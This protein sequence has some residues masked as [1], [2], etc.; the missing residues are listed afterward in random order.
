MRMLVVEDDIQ[1]AT[2]LK[3]NFEAASFAVDIAHDG[4]KGSFMARTNEY[5]IIIL[6]NVLPKKEGYVICQDIRNI[7]NNTPIIMLS[8]ILDTS[9]KVSLFQLGVDDY[10]T[11]PYSF[12]ELI[13]RVR[14]VL[15]RSQKV[16]PTNIITFGNILMDCDA[17]EIRKE[18]KPIYLTRKEFSILELLIKNSNKVVSR[19]ALMEHV[20]DMNGDPFSRTID[21][22][23]LNLRKK[24]ENKKEGKLIHNVSGR[25]YKISNEFNVF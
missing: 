22:H 19:G 7:G 12:E 10:V 8:S 20:W 15:R 14:V 1:I 4:E 5:D 18:N 23:I 2:L 6:D 17:Q 11:K 21:T 9:K 3:R 25:G 16:Y 24:I 13:A